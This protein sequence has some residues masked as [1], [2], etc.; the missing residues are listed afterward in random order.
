MSYPA[1][2]QLEKNALLVL[3]DSGGIQ[4]ET[5]VLRV[6]C[7]TL[8][9]STERPETVEVG[10]NQLAGTG[11]QNILGAAKA[12][13]QKERNWNNPFGDGTAAKKIV[14]FLRKCLP[15]VT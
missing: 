5:C 15:N 9:D 10:A 6:P 12:M 2:L 1:F 4:E 13:A 11:S 3:S 7:V 8:R 14:V